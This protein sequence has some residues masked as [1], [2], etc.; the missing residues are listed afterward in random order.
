LGEL[1]WLPAPPADWRSQLQRLHD[2]L[3]EP[4]AEAFGERAVR[5]ATAA[6]DEPQLARL[7]RLV[8]E[9]ARSGR[10]ATGLSGAKLAIIGDGLLSLLAPA[11][12]GTGLRHGLVLEVLEGGYNSGVQDAVDPSGWLNAAAPDFVLIA[13]DTRIMGL[14][15][16]AGSPDEANGRVEAAFARLE[17]MVE[18]L[19]TSVS[20]AILV[21]TLVPPLEPLFGSYD[22]VE[23]C[24]P[25]AMVEA[26]NRRISEWASRGQV[27][28][29]DAARLAASV[30]L[31]H[32]HEP[33]HWHA[34]KLCFSPSM[35]PL[36]ADVVARTIAAVRG[37][38]RKCLVLDLDNT[39][40]GGVI[41][42]D[43]LA[44]LVIGQG[45]AAGEAFLAVQQFAR[46]LRE[47][48]IVLAVCSK[49]QDDVA[50]SPF[51]EHPDMI[52]KE[53]DFAAFQ[54]NWI[55]KAA[56]LRAIA[57][58]LNIG[59]D[60]LVLLDDNPAE[61]LQVRDA[62]PLVAAPEL[63]DDPA[64]YP[65]VLAS[66]GYFEAV[67]FL[68]EDRERA[69]YYQANARRARALSAS[70]DAEAYLRSLEMTCVIR[71]VDGLSRP[72]V[73]QL[74]NKSNQ[75]N[76]TTRRYSESEVK[77]AE[78][79]PGRHL[80]QIRLIDRFGDNG[81]IS[82][83]IADKGADRWEIDTWLMSCRVLGRRVEEAALAH[84]A[85][86]A[87]REGARRLIGRYLPTAKNKL[88]ADH[89][90]RLGFDRVGEAP[91]GGELWRLDLETYTPPDLP[92]RIDD[93]FVVLQPAMP[94]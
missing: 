74:V 93:A 42:D 63:P 26:L 65:R 84:L 86:A 14:D 25:F 24:S 15:R 94:A 91:G 50:R 80:A 19:R 48:G 46:D 36:H 35:I 37:K 55:D 49:N 21:Q 1:G 72:R 2:D 16:P 11:I 52:L 4:S 41:G 28:L 68:Q 32:W 79:D 43:G 73:A 56:N 40:W 31:E 34:S 6:L 61:R 88:V 29:V 75:F 82:V 67:A 20:S 69:G 10:I 47:R 70:G 30:G 23:A 90:P 83:I 87:R 60:A 45:S 77:L 12:A 3:G 13:C 33:R 59:L 71:P 62:L 57:E 9:I 39:L 53:E 51:R 8:S 85:S 58:A 92:M 18:G 78:E 5:L 22:R 7:A 89:Y 81:V 44:G 38:S 17:L 66:A 64:L 76:L 27:V 54:A